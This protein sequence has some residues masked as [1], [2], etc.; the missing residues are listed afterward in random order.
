M[1]GGGC[2]DGW[3]GGG[4]GGSGG[5][6][7]LGGR[8][9]PIEKPQPAHT[10]SSHVYWEHHSR[11][12]ASQRSCGQASQSSSPH[13]YSVHHSA[14]IGPTGSHG[15]GQLAHSTS[16]QLIGSFIWC[17]LM[18]TMSHP[19]MRSLARRATRSSASPTLKVR[20]FDPQSGL[21]GVE[22][23]TNRIAGPRRYVLPS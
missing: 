22:T 6:G 10:A 5:R 15:H 18:Q 19:A 20:W 2:G 4:R 3:A 12:G 16:A 13:V 9:H 11:H 8:K 14:Q 23:T 17:L 1:G 21:R 7:G